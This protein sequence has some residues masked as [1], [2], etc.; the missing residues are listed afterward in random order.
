LITEFQQ[1]LVVDEVPDPSPPADG[2][3]LRV[4]ATGICKSDWHSWMGHEDLPG[5]P[6]SPVTRWLVWWMRS[7]LK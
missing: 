6:M 2:V 1:P 7:V 5:L 4:E 3:V